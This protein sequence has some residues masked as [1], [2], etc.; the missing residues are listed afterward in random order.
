MKTE[1]DVQP[2]LL[3]NKTQEAAKRH[4]ASWIELGQYLYAIHK[5]KLF[6]SWGFLSF[7]GYCVKEL[8]MKQMTASRLLKSYAFLEQEEPKVVD[9]G[10][11]DPE[12]SPEKVPNFESVNILRLAKENPKL[13]PQDYAEVRESVI[14]KAQEPKE[15]RAHVKKLLS[16]REIKDPADVR[17]ERRNAAIKRVITVISGVRRELENQKLLPEYLIKQM[18]DLTEKLRDQIED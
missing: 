1:I 8:G 3:R 17:R 7:E 14:S 18:G 5:D 16:E 6:K 15:V 4:K 10:L 11:S 2:D 9:A 12:A 13:T